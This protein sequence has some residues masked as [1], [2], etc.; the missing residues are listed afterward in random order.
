[1]ENSINKKDKHILNSLVSLSLPTMI[2]MMLQS[3]YDVVDMYWVGKIS[4]EAISAVTLFTTILWIFEV[5]NEIIG[6]S[7]VSMISQAVGRRDYDMK[8][9]ICEQTLVFKFLIGILTAI[10]MYIFIEPILL[11]YTK[12]TEVLN[13]ALEYGHLRILFIPI[14]FTSFSVNTVF[15]CTGDTKTPMIIMI[16]TAILNMILDPF[17]MFYDLPFVT[18]KG[19]NMG[20]YGAA[21]ATILSTFLSATIGFIILLK[22]TH[23]IKIK[24]KNLFRLIPSIDKNLILIGIPG[25]ME[26][27]VKFLFEAIMVKFIATYGIAALTAAGIANKIYS[28]SVLPMRGLMMGGSILLGNFLGEEDIESANNTAKISGKLNGL[29][30]FI[31]T[32]AC[33]IF[34]K[35]LIGFFSTDKEVIHL[36]SR[37]LASSSTFATLLGVSSGIGI[38][39]LG[40]GHN[41]PLLI[42]AITTQWI[43]QI[44]LMFLIV[45]ILKI[46]AQYAW[47]TYIPTDLITFIMT[48]YFYKKG[49]WMYKRV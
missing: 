15:R 26:V 11:L 14:M 16:I 49:D 36:G 23:T 3:V 28:L 22:G 1:M 45:I 29:I 42:T 47:F 40:S 19:L 6:I 7:S 5:F 33:F 44:P 38:S 20:V 18:I 10:L 43:I 37:L 24:F 30:M 4:K 2:G 31:F 25:G 13:L 8:E 32:I 41:K 27:F 35:N 21:I 34:S 48:Y 12:D 46:P 9:K 17:F 39:F